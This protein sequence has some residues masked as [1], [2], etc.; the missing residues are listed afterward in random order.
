MRDG[1][2]EMKGRKRAIREIVPD[3]LHLADFAGEFFADTMLGLSK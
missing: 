2:L 1:Y 3:G